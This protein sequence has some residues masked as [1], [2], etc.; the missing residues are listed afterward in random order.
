[1]DV[2]LLCEISY[3]LRMREEPNVRKPLTTDEEG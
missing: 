3:N 2:L 1:M